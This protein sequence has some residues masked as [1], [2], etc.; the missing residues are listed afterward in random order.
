VSEEQLAANHANA[1]PSTGPRFLH[2]KPFKALLHD[3]P[4]EM[5]CPVERA[6]PGM[7][8]WGLWPSRPG[9]SMLQEAGEGGRNG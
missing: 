7:K 2:A 5:V 9:R 1:A 6:P 3:L 8:I 4:N